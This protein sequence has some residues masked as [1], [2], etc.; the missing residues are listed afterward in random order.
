MVPLEQ[1][2][3]GS[4]L[5]ALPN[6]TADVSDALHDLTAKFRTDLDAQLTSTARFQRLVLASHE[7][8]QKRMKRCAR[9][10]EAANGKVRTTNGGHEEV[11]ELC[12]QVLGKLEGILGM[13]QGRVLDTG[14]F[15]LLGKALL[16]DGD[17]ELREYVQVGGEELGGLHY[18]QRQEMYGYAE[19]G[20]IQEPNAT[21]M[22][23][24]TIDDGSDDE[25]GKAHAENNSGDFAAS[26]ESLSKRSAINEDPYQDDERGSNNGE[27]CNE[28]YD[29][30][31]QQHDENILEHHQDGETDK[32]ETLRSIESTIN[33]HRL[34]RMRPIPL[35]KTSLSSAS[36]L[37]TETSAVV[38]GRVISGGRQSANDLLKRF[39]NSVD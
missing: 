31:D 20:Q 35:P 30:D 8:L 13:L 17:E 27:T 37:Q 9:S 5:D 10:V 36:S 6:E 3:L 28:S 16:K 23:E 34:R 7:R 14:R 2:L 38:Q 11:E 26:Q 25:G 33:R 18:A 39:V 4:I 32:E 29:E 24:L 15:P 19:N 22:G 21:E 12:G 1:T